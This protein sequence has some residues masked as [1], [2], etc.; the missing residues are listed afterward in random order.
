LVIGFISAN[1]AH[2]RKNLVKKRALIPGADLIVHQARRFIARPPQ[3][4]GSEP[5]R[6]SWPVINDQASCTLKRHPD[7]A[8]PVGSVYPIEML[9]GIIVRKTIYRAES[10]AC[11]LIERSVHMQ[12]TWRSI[13]DRTLPDVGS[14]R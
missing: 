3:E 6:E 8:R 13:R 5:P 11:R 14:K 10:N 7:N 1:D 2:E 12:L 4:R 9:T